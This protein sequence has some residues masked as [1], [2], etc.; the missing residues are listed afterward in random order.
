MLKPSRRYRS[1][2]ISDGIH[3][4]T[5]LYGSILP[6]LAIQLPVDFFIASVTMPTRSTPAPLAASITSM[7]FL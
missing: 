5:P 2:N 4:G 7:M 1:F 3:S 6:V